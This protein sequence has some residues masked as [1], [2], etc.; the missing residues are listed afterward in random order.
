M[1]NSQTKSV[2]GPCFVSTPAAKKDGKAL[3]DIG[4][5]RKI[6]GFPV[7]SLRLAGNFG[8]N[9]AILRPRTGKFPIFFAVMCYSARESLASGLSR[10]RS[11][12]VIRAGEHHQD[13]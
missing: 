10:P 1:P 8:Q 3:I 7:G 12:D 9:L 2:S 5:S 4:L 13:G 11:A 6:P